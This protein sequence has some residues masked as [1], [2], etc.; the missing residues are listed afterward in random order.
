MKK[1]FSTIICVI[2]ILTFIAQA[3]IAVE[4]CEKYGLVSVKGGEYI[5]QNNCWGSDARQCITVGD[6]NGT[7]FSVS[8][9]AHNQG[10]RFVPLDL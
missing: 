7:G 9:S 8:A 1:T 2:V 10:C 3:A 4:N 5:I 6:T